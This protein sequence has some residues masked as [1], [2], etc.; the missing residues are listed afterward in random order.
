M[1]SALPHQA[2]PCPQ[3]FSPPGRLGPSIWPRPGPARPR[4]HGHRPCGCT[5]GPPPAPPRSRRPPRRARAGRCASAS[6]GLLRSPAC[7]R[8]TGTTASSRLGGTREQVRA[9]NEGK[10]LWCLSGGDPWGLLDG[11]LGCSAPAKRLAAW[12]SP[13]SKQPG[14]LAAGP[15]ARRRVWAS[16]GA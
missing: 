9:G 7:T 11:D 10:R 5:G 12:R 14:T 8:P 4:T 15:C 3:P 16:D 2:R 6:A 13:S 1:P